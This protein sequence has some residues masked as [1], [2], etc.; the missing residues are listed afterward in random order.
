GEI[1]GAGAWG[2]GHQVKAVDYFMRAISISKEIGNEQE[3]A[4][5]YRAFADY[6][7]RS[8]PFQGNAAIQREAIRLSEMAD[9]I[10][11]RHRIEVSRSWVEFD[12]SAPS[13][14]EWGRCPRPCPNRSRQPRPAWVSPPRSKRRSPSPRASAGSSR[15]ASRPPS[16]KA[17]RG[18]FGPGRG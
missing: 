6:V 4:R 2:E 16:P 18:S 12:G 11:R 8:P 7:A 10:F 13:S 5:S 17:T 9:E 1:T 15:G 14:A 3:V